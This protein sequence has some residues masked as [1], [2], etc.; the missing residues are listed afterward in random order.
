MAESAYH[1]Y[2]VHISIKIHV[3]STLFI[4]KRGCVSPPK[5]TSIKCIKIAYLLNIVLYAILIKSKMA[6]KVWGIKHGIFKK[7]CV[8]EHAEYKCF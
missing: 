3:V 5:K 2:I 8:T 7:R 1:S 4:I 6:E